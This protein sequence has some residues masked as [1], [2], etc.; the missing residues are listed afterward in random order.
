MVVRTHTFQHIIT[1]ATTINVSAKQLSW[2][3]KHDI[4]QNLPCSFEQGEFCSSVQKSRSRSTCKACAH[5]RRD[6]NPHSGHASLPLSR[7]PVQSEMVQPTCPRCPV[8]ARVNA[9]KCHIVVAISHQRECRSH[10]TSFQRSLQPLLSD[11]FFGLGGIFNAMRVKSTLSCSTRPS[12]AVSHCRLLLR[13]SAC[14]RLT[15]IELLCAAS[16][17][18]GLLKAHSQRCMRCLL[19]HCWICCEMLPVPMSLL[20]APEGHH[21]NPAPKNLADGVR[22][23]LCHG[24]R[25]V[26]R[27]LFLCTLLHTFAQVKSTKSHC[28]RA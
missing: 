3:E 28:P 8:H 13:L 15:K 27:S 18:A 19:M 9:L 10:R 2:V 22:V 20:H 16:S 23:S 6:E 26:L 5:R 25:I 17:L 1:Q 21:L 12:S 7:F 14:F 24:A 11:S 4:V